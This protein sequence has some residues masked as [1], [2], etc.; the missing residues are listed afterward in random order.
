MPPQ[1]ALEGPGVHVA[2]H[3]WPDRQ[4]AQQLQSDCEAAAA[5][6]RFVTEAR[7]LAS[8]LL[9]GYSRTRNLGTQIRGSEIQTHS[10]RK[11]KRKIKKRESSCIWARR[12]CNWGVSK[13]RAR[14]GEAD[15]SSSKQ[16]ESI[17]AGEGNSEQQQLGREVRREVQRI[18][19][20]AAPATR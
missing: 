11:R 2:R 4:E 1:Q 6:A 20:A 5:K 14:R 3:H 9:R 18:T 8:T 17:C 10:Q 19:P 16:D 15:S 13:A 12:S 7:R